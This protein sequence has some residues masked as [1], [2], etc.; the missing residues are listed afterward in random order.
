MKKSLILFLALILLTPNLVFS[1]IFTFK[2]GFFIPQAKYDIREDNLWWIEFDQMGFSKTNFQN[3]NFGFSYEYF[4]TR[5]ISL[6]IGVDG[7]TKKKTSAYKDYVGYLGSTLGENWDFAFPIDYEGDFFPRHSFSVSITPIQLSLKLTPMGRRSK[8]I[9]YIGGGV[10]VYLWDVR[11]V[12]D[13]IDFEDE[14]LYFDP[15]LGADI[16]V[17]P[18]HLVSAIEDNRLTIGYH[19]FG[20]IM[21]PVAQRFTL[22]VEFKYNYARGELKEGFEGFEFFDLSAYQVSLGLNYWF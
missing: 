8:I 5:Q 18:I 22:E 1:G 6:A 7:Y 9:P 3:T 16:P 13:M 4:I 17:Y 11:L 10:G 21:I 15:D 12:G 19:A 20:G 2:V 14:W